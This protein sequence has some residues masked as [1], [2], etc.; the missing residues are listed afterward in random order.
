MLFAESLAS[1]NV[2]Q[3]RGLQAHSG[4]EKIPTLELTQRHTWCTRSILFAMMSH[5]QQYAEI[6]A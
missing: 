3:N 6:S 4:E 5:P 2:R 1:R